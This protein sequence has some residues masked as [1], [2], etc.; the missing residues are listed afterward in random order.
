MSHSSS[1][2][3]IDFLIQAMLRCYGVGNLLVVFKETSQC[4]MVIFPSLSL[5]LDHDRIILDHQTID[6]MR[7]IIRGRE[8]EIPIS[9]LN[10]SI[11]KRKNYNNNND[12]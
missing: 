3:M 1:G 6:Q 9:V 4:L 2:C 12:V 7:E 11:S 10:Q 8:K 5:T